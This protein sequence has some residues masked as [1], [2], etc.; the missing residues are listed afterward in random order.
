MFFGMESLQ[1]DSWIVLFVI[2]SLDLMDVLSLTS[3]L[4]TAFLRIVSSVCVFL[5]SDLFY[6][7]TYI[8]ASESTTER[9]YQT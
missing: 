1:A 8:R 3:C 9:S 7:K 2:P 5:L 6:A 4:T